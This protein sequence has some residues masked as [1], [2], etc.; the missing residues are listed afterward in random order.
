MQR[1]QIIIRSSPFQ[2]LKRLV[3]IQS[4]FAFS[5]FFL[6]LIISFFV[7]DA[8]TLYEQFLLARSVPYEL[9]ITLIST[10][11]QL[12]ILGG[13]FITWYFPVYLVTR[14]H[15][16]Y[17]RGSFLGNRRL[18]STAAIT[19]MRVKQ[20]WLAR[21]MS[22][23]TV[24]IETSAAHGHISLKDIPDPFN[25][26]ELIW[27]LVQPEISEI[28]QAIITPQEL[29]SGGENQQVEFKASLMWDYRRQRVNKELYV[30]VMKNLA[31][32]MN[33]NGG[34]LFIGVDD[35]GQVLGLDNDLQ[36]MRKSDTD[37]YE[38][39][40]NQ[41][42]NKMIGVEF[43]QFVDAGFPIIDGQAV[44]VLRVR[45]STIPAYITH[46]GEERFYIR[47][48]NASQP[49]TISQAARYIPQRYTRENLI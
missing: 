19:N 35:N 49:L 27:D 46:K 23:G 1:D 6:V 20:G 34:Y 21:Q 47:A 39:T 37:G 43:R 3:L 33:S 13:A 32:F 4:L 15:I 28:D 42:F 26:M 18:V 11:L 44:C 12:L 24:Q 17:Q 8:R 5:P 22:Y 36:G 16:N 45:P 7:A 41:A 10:F 48:G 30:P 40:F 14:Q 25:H 29:I 9:F 2:F 31:A 38:N